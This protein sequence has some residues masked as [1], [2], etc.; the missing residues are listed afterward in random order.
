MVYQEISMLS[1]TGVNLSSIIKNV[2]HL[3][4][5][6]FVCFTDGDNCP[7]G[8]SF[9]KY[10]SGSKPVL[11]DKLRVFA[12]NEKLM[13]QLNLR[14]R[15]FKIKSY[16]KI[17]E[18]RTVPATDTYAMY[19]RVHDETNPRLA[20]YRYVKRHPEVSYEEARKMLPPK[21]PI[22]ELPY[23]VTESASSGQTFSLFIKKTLCAEE[24][25]GRYNAYGL[26]K[27]KTVPEF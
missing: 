8:I 24:T 1:G 11:G 20:A 15:L 17:S 10:L 18:I 3:L 13:E 19:E 25:M 14:D 4:H 5:K 23:I 12:E 16:V 21:K 26:G 9:P 27:G 7:F 2:Y 22:L 6:G